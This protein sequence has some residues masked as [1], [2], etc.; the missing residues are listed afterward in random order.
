MLK[1]PAVLTLSFLE[2]IILYTVA[3][4]EHIPNLLQVLSLEST[5]SFTKPQISKSYKYN[6]FSVINRIQLSYAFNKIGEKNVNHP[7]L[8][9][10]QNTFTKLSK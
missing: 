10:K 1:F 9:N 4:S 3:L 2:V 7:N 8:N 6:S 5:F